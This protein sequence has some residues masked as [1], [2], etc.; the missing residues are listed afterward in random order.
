M[1]KKLYASQQTSP[2]ELLFTNMNKPLIENGSDVLIVK[3][4]VDH[5]SVLPVLYQFGLF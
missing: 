5:A 3:R 2:G 4:I 1:Q